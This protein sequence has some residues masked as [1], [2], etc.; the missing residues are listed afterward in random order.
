MRSA[1]EFIGMDREELNQ[2]VE[3]AR[4][5]LSAQEYHKLKGVVEA[6]SYSLIWSRISRLRFVIC[7]S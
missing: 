3:H 4:R 5:S 1:I 7:A 6:L 2:L